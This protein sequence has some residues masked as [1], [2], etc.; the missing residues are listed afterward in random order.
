MTLFKP[1]A[2]VDRTLLTFGFAADADGDATQYADPDFE[3]TYNGNITGAEGFDI[4]LAGGTLTYG[5]TAD[6]NILQTEE[7]TNLIL[8]NSNLA[9]E[10]FVG[11]GKISADGTNNI[12]LKGDEGAAQLE[13][14]TVNN[15]ATVEVDA[16]EGTVEITTLKN[17]GNA[18]FK[19]DKVLA[20][21]ISIDKYYGTNDSNILL[22]LGSYA[23]SQLRGN[24][25]EEIALNGAQVLV[26]ND[27]ET[28]SNLNLHIAEGEINGEINAVI[29]PSGQIIVASEEKNPMVEALRDITSSG[30]Q[31]FRAQMNDLEKRMGDLRDMP[32]RGGA[33]AKFINGQS[34]Y[35]GLHNDYK[36]FQFGAD[37]YLGD[38]DIYVGLMGSHTDGDGKLKQGSTDDKNYS[39]GLYGGWLGKDGQFID[40]T[41]KH[42]HIKSD[43]DFT[44]NNNY[45][46]GKYST[47]GFSSSIEYG[48]RLG[49]AE[50]N[51]YVEPQTEFLY[52]RLDGKSY[53]TSRGVK[54]K[55]SDIKSVVGRLGVAVGW[56]PPHKKGNIYVKASVLNDWQ[57]KSKITVSND[58][59]SRQYREDMGGTWGRFALGGTGNITDNIS[60]YGEAET[61]VGKH[62]RKTYEYNVGLRLN[63]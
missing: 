57:G 20:E 47:S 33:W 15:S 5:G 27:N 9:I 36:T 59:S 37:H 26:I 35:K 58:V 17:S 28:S 61:T 1:G 13:N 38:S 18:E 42:H 63:F 51:F 39:F 16:G 10:S 23:V 3:M 24:S 8:S 11:Y 56:L 29:N 41:L 54:V 40:M 53:T 46:E 34:K 60:A 31:I 6:V 19:S 50:T 21:Q 7:D 4:Q 44:A 49:I 43:F 25:V 48:W 30:F 12:V 55:Q 14:L 52:G 62:V 32:G 22:D 45:S 2:E